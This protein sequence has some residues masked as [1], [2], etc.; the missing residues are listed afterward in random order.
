MTSAA[1]DK[2]FFHNK[3]GNS[4]EYATLPDLGGV[5]KTCGWNFM[6]L[7]KNRYNKS[8]PI[9]GGDVEGDFWNK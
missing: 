5:C 7:I 2:C 1:P 3:C 8:A 6:Q 4:G 9:G